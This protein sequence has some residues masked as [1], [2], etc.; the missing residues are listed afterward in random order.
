MSVEE[1]LSIFIIGFL[2]GI[3]FSAISFIIGTVVNFPL[4]I[5]RKG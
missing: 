2:G 1:L 4:H 3:F 5:I